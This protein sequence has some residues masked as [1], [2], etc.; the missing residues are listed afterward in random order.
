[1]DN[2]FEI[3]IYLAIL[4]IGGIISANRN[5]NKRKSVLHPPFQPQAKPVYEDSHQ[6]DYNPLEEFLKKYEIEENPE[7]E[8]QD[9]EPETEYQPEKVLTEENIITPEKEGISAFDRI[10][11]TIITDFREEDNE[12]AS[13]QITDAVEGDDLK[14]EIY[15]N[16]AE[17]ITQGIIYS[18]I[19]KR[20]QF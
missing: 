12:I 7:Y 2:L 19:L 20:K 8:S 1:M 10:V 11:D 14:S 13:G 16:L 9:I 15:I 6:P 5:K 17:N 18:E 3:I 4:V